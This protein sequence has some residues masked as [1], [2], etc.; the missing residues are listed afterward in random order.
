MEKR[1]DSTILFVGP[2]PPRECGIGTFTKDI[3]DYINKSFSPIIRTKILALNKNGSN[4]YNYPKNVIFQIS[5]NEVED[6]I[7]A[8][9]KINRSENIKLVCIQHEFGLFGGEYG[10]YLLA[11]LEML[12]KPVII[13]FHSLISNPNE[14]L[15]KVVKAISERVKG[16]VVMTKKGVEIL[17]KD[18]GICSPHIQI[19][20]IP[21]GIPNVLFENQKKEKKN[22]GFK[23]RIII[24]SFGLMNK[25]K[26]YEY[27][28]DALPNLIKKHPNLL[29]LIVG[30]THP[31]VRKVEGEEYRNF[32]EKKVKELGLQKHVKFYN[33]YLKLD[34][35]IRYL[36]ASDIYISSNLDPDQ[37]T[38]GT[39]VYAM[40][41]G[42]VVVS[43]PFLH[44][45]D[46]LQEGLGKL[47]DFKN[48]GS[49]VEAINEILDNQEKKILM[50]RNAYNYTRHMTWQ[51]VSLAYGKFFR[52]ILN[53]PDIPNLPKINTNHMFRLTDNFGIIQF[54]NQ[55]FPDIKSGYTL[56]DNSR[57]LIVS[58]MHYSNFKEFKSLQLL[59]IY[60]NYLK[61]VQ[62]ENGRFYNYVD[63]N[64]KINF[65]DWS[66]DA[67]GR[68]VWALGMMLKNKSIPED[69]KRGGEKLLKKS[70]PVVMNLQSPRAI[71]FSLI[72]LCHAQ[73]S[74]L[75]DFKKQ[76][77]KLADWLVSAYNANNYEKWHWFE[78]YLTY[79]NSKLPES[80]F[81][82]YS[83]INDE[84]YCEVAEKSLI[85][86]ISKTFHNSTFIPIGQ[87]GWYLKGQKRS[88]FDQQ[89]IEAAYMVQTLL[90]AYEITRKTFF[91]K[92]SVDAF[93]WFLGKNSLSQV[94]YNESTGGCYDGLGKN[95]ININ[96][97]AESTLSYLI[98]RLSLINMY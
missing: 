88:Y 71:A 1:D 57:A 2:Y 33:K 90:V 20:L 46:I 75:I 23:D 77:K 65:N 73:E 60:L 40:G 30:E 56:D 78:P 21:H 55:H 8:A 87:N 43:T 52:E 41:C 6:Y 34:E 85:F 25:G 86:L 5:D 12:E 26:G 7:E 74:G 16:I 66:E 45:K 64:R 24:S 14:R 58:V 31:V 51:N 19:K 68:A 18:Y 89:P 95:T 39:L 29:Y 59:K 47:V 15:R 44:A 63:K 93:Q 98:A 81:L 79:S 36:K 3:S 54:S 53:I 17:K 27:V 50:E 91:K 42:R 84:K 28:I 48:P 92:R 38:S 97:G 9:K 32:L 13:T 96:Q 37:I 94:I 4:I 67:H 61:Y 22:I 11:F 72:G 10:D 80:L 62:H 82:A 76:I 83:I 49:Y 69:F 35:I 70:I